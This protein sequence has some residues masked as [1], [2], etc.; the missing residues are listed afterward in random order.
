M[1]KRDLHLD[2]FRGVFLVVMTADHWPGDFSRPLQQP[3]GLVSAAEGFVFV[4]GLTAGLVYARMARNHGPLHLRSRAFRRAREIYQ[5]H[6][7]FLAVIFALGVAM[8]AVGQLPASWAERIPFLADQPVRGLAYGTL[9]V[10]Q[11]KYFNIL[12]LYILLL[13]L[14][15]GILGAIRRG[16]TAIVLAASGLVWCLA[17]LEV[18]E[19]LYAWFTR[20]LG[21]PVGMFFD[22]LAWQFLFVLGL[23]F[24]ASREAGTLRRPRAWWLTLACLAAAVVLAWYRYQLKQEVYPVE[25]I[26]GVDMA[27]WTSRAKLGPLRLFNFFILAYLTTGLVTRFP[28]AFTGRWFRFLGRHSLQVFS[29]HLLLIYLAAAVQDWGGLPAA[30]GPAF[31]FSLLGAA[32]LTLPAYLSTKVGRRPFENPRGWIVR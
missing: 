20:D 22:P 1:V 3:L 29:Y 21:H 27:N 14:T 18:G 25:Q 6:V 8:Q 4:S 5:T 12:P 2:F 26:L 24:G 9:L 10:F 16:R 17:Q 11:P 19:A 28:R 13:M 7:F 23:W 15:P 32:S 31:W 30:R